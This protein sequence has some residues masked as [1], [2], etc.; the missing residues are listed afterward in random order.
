MIIKC[1]KCKAA[2]DF[3]NNFILPKKRKPMFSRRFKLNIAALFLLLLAMGFNALLSMSSLEKLY[4][5]SI[6]SK[7]QVIGKDLQRN[8]QKGLRFGKSMTKYVGIDRMLEDTVLN[9][10]RKI[11]VNGTR[12]SLAGGT[13]VLEKDVAVSICLPGGNII[14]S[15]DKNS[16][17]T[18]APESVLGDYHADNSKSAS[19]DYIKYQENYWISLPVS[20]GLKKKYIGNILIVFN[21]KPVKMLLHSVF[22]KNLYTIIFIV[23]CG[24]ILMTFFL[25]LIANKNSDGKFPKFKITVVMFIVIG[26]S[27]IVFS[28]LNLN[29]FKNYYLEINREK[30]V[31]L[32][33]M[34]KEDVE[35][36]LSKGLSMEK[37]YKIDA[38]MEEMIAASPEL[39]NITIFN[40]KGFALYKATKKGVVDFNKNKPDDDSP[41]V[42]NTDKDPKYSLLLGIVKNKKLEGYISTSTDEGYISANISRKVLA[43]KLKTIVF[44]SATVLIISILFFVEMLILTFQYIEKSAKKNRNK[45]NILAMRPVAFMF[46]FG[47]DISISFLPLHMEKLYEPVFGLPK[48]I[49][50][51]LP[52]SIQMFFTAIFILISGIWCDRRGWHEPFL[53]GLVLSSIGFIYSWLAPD[54]IHFLFSLGLVGIG[55]GLSLMSCQGY[56][57][58][59]AEPEKKALGIAQMIAGIYAGSICGGAAGGMLADRIGYPPVFCIGGI[60]LLFVIVYTIAT[61]RHAMQKPEKREKQEIR[62]SVGFMQIIR[63]LFNPSIMGLILLSGIPFAIAMVGF[64]NYFS[65]IHL[66]SIGA[67]KSDIG[68]ILMVYGICL[69]YISPLLTKYVDKFS[70]K[71]I[72]IGISGFL[73]ALAF[74]NYYY[75]GSYGIMAVA[76]SIFLLGLSA[77]FIPCRNAYLLTFSVSQDLGEG[78]AIGLFNSLVRTGQVIGPL[79]FGWLFI[80]FETHNGIVIL[81]SAYLLLT[82]LFL[83]IPVERNAMTIK[84]GR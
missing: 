40:D 49:V 45:V 5:E 72:F 19:C 8:I 71:K 79:L 27:Q 76:F 6:V 74:I 18:Y 21:E 22:Q 34:L 4:V 1:E 64:L 23:V 52:I 38:L 36:F 33:T 51:G 65:P 59:H 66:N 29:G 80:N 73:G 82:I 7:Y 57:L 63:F 42:T 28:I 75:W 30:M 58:A 56:I 67:S 37:L 50:I 53:T 12:K 10:T 69:I 35:F 68:R 44:D 14:Y 54:A 62:K 81:G 61:M 47:I 55:Y 43:D 41:N 26:M 77:S 39:D 24:F 60:I 78:E 17:T 20:G 84:N 48:D 15:T 32:A 9:I 25:N 13:K 16:V 46:F 70:N 83:L 31:L 3:D 2:F 11:D